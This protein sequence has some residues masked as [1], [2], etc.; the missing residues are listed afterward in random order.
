MPSDKTFWNSAH[1][2][3]VDKF[4]L[5]WGIEFELKAKWRRTA[6]GAGGFVQRRLDG[7]QEVA[8]IEGL[9]DIAV[10]PGDL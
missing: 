7:I 10:G 2:S 6:S 1:G 3:L 5:S 4:G 9:E 8:L